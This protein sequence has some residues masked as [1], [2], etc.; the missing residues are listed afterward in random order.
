MLPQRVTVAIVIWALTIGGLTS[1][2]LLRISE[3]DEHLKFID[4]QTV[5]IFLIGVRILLWTLALYLGFL[6]WSIDLTGWLASAGA[7]GLVL[8]LAAKD[9]L[10][11]LIAG[12]AL[13]AKILSAGGFIRLEDG[14]SG[15][16]VRIGMRST[17]IIT[18]DGVQ[19]IPNSLLSNGY[20]VN[21]SAGP[22]RTL[23]SPLRFRWH[24]EQTWNSLFKSF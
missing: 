23:G 18:R 6:T 10:A 21:T 20:V 11:N 19:M 4:E 14:Q 9:T 17:T 22:T 13:L 7:L 1:R 8:G 16:V 2:A 3:N 15:K 24:T 5:G 12:L